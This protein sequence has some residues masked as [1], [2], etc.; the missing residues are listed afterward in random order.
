MRVKDGITAQ[1]HGPK[2]HDEGL[3]KKYRAFG[4]DPKGKPLRGK[5]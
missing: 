2:M 4:L 1:A 3:K 5:K